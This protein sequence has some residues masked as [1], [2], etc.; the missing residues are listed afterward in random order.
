MEYLYGSVTPNMQSI[1]KYTNIYRLIKSTGDLNSVQV[2]T[3]RVVGRQVRYSE[4]PK[5]GIYKLYF[6]IGLV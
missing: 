2:P 1:L 6:F 5:S 4:T 3:T